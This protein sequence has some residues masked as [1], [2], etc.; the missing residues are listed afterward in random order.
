MPRSVLRPPAVRVVTSRAI[1][2]LW[3]LVEGGFT[4]LKALPRRSYHKSFQTLTSAPS[5]GLLFTEILNIVVLLAKPTVVIVIV[6]RPYCCYCS[7]TQTTRNCQPK[8]LFFSVFAF[9]F[10]FRDESKRF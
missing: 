4:A 1:D 5:V 9:F 6:E 2:V 8:R 7:T 3:W 10:G